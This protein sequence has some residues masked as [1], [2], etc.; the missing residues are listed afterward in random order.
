[1]KKISL[2]TAGLVFSCIFLLNSCGK[3][4]DMVEIPGKNFMM[5]STEITQGLYESVMGHNPS[6]FTSENKDLSENERK[7][8]SDDTWSYPVECVS[9]YD[10]IYFCN[11]LSFKKG[12][13][14]VYYVNDE[15]DTDKW[16]YTPGKSEPI[17]GKIEV[18]KR[19]NGFRLP[20]LDEWNYAAACNS[21]YKYSGSDIVGEVAWYSNNSN[22]VTHPVAKKMANEFGLYD[23]TGNVDEWCWEHPAKDSDSRYVCGGTIN[24]DNKISLKNSLFAKPASDLN[25]YTGFRVVCLKKVSDSE[26]KKA[27]KK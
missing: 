15:A 17:K 21:S 16:E 13:E 14:P 12:L 9:W 20:T 5:S 3:D 19:A 7:N 4:I 26:D 1:M 8:I 25:V 27:E 10:A 22:S 6:F 24:Y 23:M 2:I 11:K 18:S